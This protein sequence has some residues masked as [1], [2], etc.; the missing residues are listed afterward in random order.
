MAGLWPAG[1]EADP[2]AAT[3]VAAPLILTAALPP[4]LGAVLD[5]W[6]R[7]HYAQ[8]A[9]RAPAHLTLF[10]HLPGLQ[11]PLLAADARRVLAQ[12]PPL[13]L[14]LAPPAL[15][16]GA[17][18]VRVRSPMLTALRRALADLWDP[19]LLPGDRADP[20]LHVTLAGRKAHPVRLP[21]RR[22]GALQAEALSPG[23][24]L[25]RHGE[26][27]WTPLVALRHPR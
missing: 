15:R 27:K 25:W 10:R 12:T 11:A 3:P 18:V 17:L 8:G 1:W 19:W 7:S 2:G 6:R 26:P 5:D 20:D 14:R 9:A 23:L 4:A 24:L 21:D 16:D 22:A 13:H